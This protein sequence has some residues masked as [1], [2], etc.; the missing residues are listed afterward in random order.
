MRAAHGRKKEQSDRTEYCYN[1]EFAVEIHVKRQVAAW[2]ELL[3]SM[4]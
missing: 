2:S 4:R 1:G 3:Y